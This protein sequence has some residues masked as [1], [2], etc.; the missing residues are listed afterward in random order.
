MEPSK[1]ALLV[2]ATLLGL[3]V[4]AQGKGARASA[5]SLRPHLPSAE[6]PGVEVRCESVRSDGPAPVLVP[7]GRASP[8]AASSLDSTT[9]PSS[10]LLTPSA[11]QAQ[12]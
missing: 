8:P 9:T 12:P 2:V 7:A 5:I 1:A 4:L 10:P 3:L 6:E 11:S